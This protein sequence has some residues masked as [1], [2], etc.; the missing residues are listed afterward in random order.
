MLKKD[1]IP[2]CYHGEWPRP[3]LEAVGWHEAGHALLAAYWG[4]KIAQIWIGDGRKN[5]L[6]GDKVEVAGT[7]LSMM[8]M[9]NPP[10]DEEKWMGK[11]TGV[12]QSI[13]PWFSERLAPAYDTFKDLHVTYKEFFPV[14]RFIDGAQLDLEAALSMILPMYQSVGLNYF[15]AGEMFNLEF[16]HPAEHIVHQHEE[17]LRAL[18]AALVDKRVL[19]GEEI[20]DVMCHAGKTG[21]RLPGCCS[22]GSLSAELRLALTRVPQMLTY[23]KRMEK[24]GIPLPTDGLMPVMQIGDKD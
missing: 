11:H 2:A 15:S 16:M 8:F 24:L 12:Y 18:V 4:L 9:H 23:Q 5:C 14:G 1:E 10:T 6:M 19:S 20:H 22:D 21:G 7:T 17:Q 3:V 13:G